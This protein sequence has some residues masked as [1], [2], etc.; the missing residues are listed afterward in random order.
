MQTGTLGRHGFLHGSLRS[1]SREGAADVLSQPLLALSIEGCTF[2]NAP[3]SGGTEKSRR[4]W[5]PPLSLTC[6]LSRPCPF[7]K[8]A[9]GCAGSMAKDLS[10]SWTASLHPL[11]NL[12]LALPLKP[13]ARSVRTR[14]EWRRSRFTGKDLQSDRVFP[15]SNRWVR[16]ESRERRVDTPTQTTNVLAVTTSGLQATSSSCKGDVLRL[17]ISMRLGSSTRG[18]RAGHPT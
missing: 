15:F 8:N 10:I 11:P 9:S 6:I 14:G 1:S 13:R 17:L 4:R 16:Q 18:Q 12:S 5:L 3:S 2:S 7:C